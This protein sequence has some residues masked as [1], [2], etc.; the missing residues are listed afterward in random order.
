MDHYQV[1]GVHVHILDH[2]LQEQLLVGCLHLGEVA[3]DAIELRA[4]GHVED[5][6]DVEFLEGD[7]GSP[8]LVHVDV[9]QEQGVATTTHSLCTFPHD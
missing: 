4:V 3:L 1:Y 2:V 7:F 8:G 5:F 9:V 6:G